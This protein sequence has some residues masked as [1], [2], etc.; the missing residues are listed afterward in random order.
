MRGLV[1]IQDLVDLAEPPLGGPSTATS[2]GQQRNE[3]M[4]LDAEEEEPEQNSQD[5]PDSLGEANIRLG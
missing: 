5:P 3:D 2:T 4:E 1:K